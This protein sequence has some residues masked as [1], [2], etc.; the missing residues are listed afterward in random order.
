M[1]IRFKCDRCGKTVSGRDECAAEV[2]FNEHTCEGMRP[3]T[4]LPLPL[5]RAVAVG[6]L[7]EA[8]A[9]SKADAA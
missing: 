8:E 2:A 7:T 6:E 5:L 4:D 1:T 3:L 9:W